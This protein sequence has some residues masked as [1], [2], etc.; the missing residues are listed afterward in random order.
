MTARRGWW[1]AILIVALAAAGPMGLRVALLT[2]PFQTDYNEGWN[3]YRAA[4]VA[5]GGRLYAAAPAGWVTYYP[6]LSFHLVAWLPAGEVL[7]GR[8]LAL[9]GLAM[10]CAGVFAIVR[11]LAGHTHA[12]LFAA[13]LP[14]AWI[15][16]Y[17]TGYIA[18]YDP[19][20]PAAA[21]A[22]WGVWAYLRGWLGRSALLFVLALFLKQSVVGLPFAVALHLVV[23]RRWSDLARWTAA[24][25]G[26]AVLLA[27]WA[28][29]RH[30]PHLLDHILAPRGLDPGKGLRD[31][32]RFLV[33]FAGPVAICAGWGWRQRLAVPHG[34]PVLALLG[35]LAAAL[36]LSPGAGLD[37]N[38]FFDAMLALAMATGVAL[39]ALLARMKSAALRTPLLLLPLLPVVLWLPQRLAHGIAYVREAP[40]DAAQF[41]EGVRLLAGLGAPVLCENLQLCFAAGLPQSDDPFFT[42]DAARREALPESSIAAPIAARHWR[43][44][45]LDR[46]AMEPLAP[47]VRR[48]RFPA[49]AVDAMVANYRLAYTAPRFAILVPRD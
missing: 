7:A 4:L 34:L 11:R 43:A 31:T 18:M 6:P 15:G 36:A 44:I 33:L 25:S 19:H 46:W 22:V 27:G 2:V 26:A 41:A 17:A 16:S 21:L 9:A 48:E 42:D 23:G 3:A 40:R 5:T 47:G 12:A 30:G 14:V 49:A 28:M 32:A 45:V 20:L 8:L 37:R 10:C 39:P 35:G 38:A 13:L 1:V 29:A 24:G